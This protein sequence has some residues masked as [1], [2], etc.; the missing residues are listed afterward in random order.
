MAD[1]THYWY[2]RAKLPERHGQPCRIVATG[3]LNS[4]LVEFADGFRVVTSRRA[5]R[6][7]V[8]VK[9]AAKVAKLHRELGGSA[10]LR[11]VKS[12]SANQR[13][14]WLIEEGFRPAQLIERLGE[15]NWLRVRRSLRIPAGLRDAVS[16]L[17][18]DGMN[19]PIRRSPASADALRKK[20]VTLIHVLSGQLG[21]DEET[22]R[23]ML[24]RITGKRSSKDLT[25]PER[26][27]VLDH[28]KAAGGKITTP[29]KAARPTP[30]GAAPAK[31]SRT[32][33]T[34]AQASKVRALWLALHQLG[35]VRD[36]SESAL[37]AYCKR[38]AKV[39]ALQW[40]TGAQLSTLIETL[41]KWENRARL[42]GVSQVAPRSD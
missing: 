3:R 28:L 9:N 37:G 8:A 2:W 17:Y 29:R 36:S 7:V 26:K 23:D 1:L 27:R 25:W 32:L 22:R 33:D 21:L 14:S 11:L 6:K 38:I 16:K 42:S 34:S 41:K 13:L 15:A 18:E 5:V 24:A 12:D 40:A 4:A 39:N 20:E 10:A 31:P 19:T 30:D 35:A